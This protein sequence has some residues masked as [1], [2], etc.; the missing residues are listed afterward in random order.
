MVNSLNTHEENVL[1]LCTFLQLLK[2]KG[3]GEV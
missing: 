3:A 1:D 2:G